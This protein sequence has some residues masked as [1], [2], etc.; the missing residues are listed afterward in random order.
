MKYVDEFRDPEKAK[1]LIRE[2]NSLVDRIEICRTRPL[3]IM[4]VCG[5]HTH[6]IFR[7]GVETMLPDEIEAGVEKVF[8]GG[9]EVQQYRMLEVHVASEGARLAANDTR[10]AAASRPS[11]RAMNER[12]A[13]P[14]PRTLP[15]A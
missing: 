6:A 3:Y 14:L 9:L 7:Y 5:G 1:F 2:I 4:E 11:G 8:G 12:M 10:R 15:A 13:P